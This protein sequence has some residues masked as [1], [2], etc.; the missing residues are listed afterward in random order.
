MDTSQ[1]V[2]ALGALHAKDILYADLKPENLVIDGEGHIK[3]TDFG[4]CRTNV[5]S[6]SGTD[7]KPCY[8][9]KG[10]GQLGGT[11]EYFAPE[12][13]LTKEQGPLG[14]ALDWWTLGVLSYELFHK[15]TT[16]V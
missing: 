9:S 7:G 8:V 12:L 13:I 3:I 14:K 5:E 11:E 1:V 4:L 15:V 2:C 16:L 6:Y 10:R